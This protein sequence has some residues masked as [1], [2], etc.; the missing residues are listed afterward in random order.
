[1]NRAFMD[2]PISTWLFP[3]RD[4]RDRLHP[5]FF[6][7]FLDLGFATGQ[8]LTTED[9]AG[10]IV[11]WDEPPGQPDDDPTLNERF[12]TELGNYHAQ[13]VA[14]FVALTG[15][16]HPRHE[17]H[18]YVPFVAVDPPKW[19]RGIGTQL[20]RAQLD[21]VTTPVYLEASSPRNAELYPRMG[22]APWGEPVNLPGGPSL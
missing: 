17:A 11:S 9:Q 2:D 3:D 4:D 22:F 6:G 16:T 1:M 13:R 5:R 12:Q 15:A 10:L 7:V 21:T 19:G 14:M 8:V 20:L 18:T